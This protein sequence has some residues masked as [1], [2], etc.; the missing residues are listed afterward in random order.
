MGRFEETLTPSSES[1]PPEQPR[2]IPLPPADAPIGVAPSEQLQAPAAERSQSLP[3][4]VPAHDELGEQSAQPNDLRQAPPT[5]LL[6]PA[7]IDKVRRTLEAVD[8]LCGQIGW[9]GGEG[10]R[11]RA[12]M[13][14]ASARLV[15]P[16]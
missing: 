3:A 16:S 4:A 1:L 13:A 14:Q 2:N 5:E 8:R 6:R 7:E 15:P 9:L 11:L 12:L 10:E